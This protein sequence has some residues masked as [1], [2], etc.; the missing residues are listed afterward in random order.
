[1]LIRSRK[2]LSYAASTIVLASAVAVAVQP[3]TMAAEPVDITLEVASM[4]TL[5]P[6]G[7]AT[8]TPGITDFG[9]IFPG[10]PAVTTSDCT[11]DF[12][13]TND[14]AKLYL[15][16]S[17]GEGGAM[18]GGASDGSFDPGFGGG[19]GVVSHSLIPTSPEHYF[20]A[21]LQPD[22]KVVAVGRTWSDGE[23]Q[24]SVSRH[25]PD[26][27]FDEDFGTDGNVIVDP[28]VHEQ[29][30]AVAIELD[31]HILV[32]GHTQ[33]VG[34]LPTMV[35]R[36]TSDGELDTDW[37]DSGV[38]AIDAFPGI[39]EEPLDMLLQADGKIVIV[40]VAGTIG[41]SADAYALR[42]LPDG[43]IDPTYGVNGVRVL[44]IDGGLDVAWRAVLQPDGHVV[45]VGQAYESV[46]GSNDLFG[47]RL[48]PTGDLDTT[49]GG[50]GIVTVDAS[51]T[52]G[53]DD[54]GMSI[55]LQ[56]DGK[57][58]LGGSTRMTTPVDDELFVVRV[59]ADGTLDTTFATGGRFIHDQTVWND[60]VVDLDVLPDGTIALAGS[61]VTSQVGVQAWRLTSRGVRDTRFSGDGFASIATPG[62]TDVNVREQVI[63]ADGS[64]LM[65]GL[66][67]NGGN[68]DYLLARFDSES[69]PG[70]TAGAWAAETPIFGACMRDGTGVTATWAESMGLDC[71]ADDGASWH[72]IETAVGVP[73]EVARIGLGDTEGTVSLR[74]GMQVADDHRPGALVAPI[75]FSVVS[76][77]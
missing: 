18:W 55:G 60:N 41:P 57:I 64:V 1:V 40:G 26:G 36:L 61:R 15:T 6:G 62:G 23:E 48:T 49:F 16:Q 12:G 29:A 45:I 8:G 34:T 25:D 51:V 72:G 2:L 30:T 3:A 37:A 46:H 50:D 56:A 5:D 31:G 10:A 32:A 65:V 77:A 53:T 21:A 11:I 69:I 42:L 54:K 13:A 39:P 63:H 76:P 28:A 58:L 75:T 22:M 73:A 74:F 14:S 7:C 66:L 68:E 27:S 43:A 17:D 44:D 35:V 70:Y 52:G 59:A 67:T 9:T 24:M 47:A 71:T 20:D 4:T 38:S 19:D 33:Y